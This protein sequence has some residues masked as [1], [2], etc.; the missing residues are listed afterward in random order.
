M[1]EPIERV[2]N[3][4]YTCPDCG[5]VYR[6]R[7]SYD[8]HLG[9][10]NPENHALAESIVGRWLRWEDGV[11]DERSVHVG[12]AVGVVDYHLVSVY[13]LTVSTDYRGYMTRTRDYEWTVIRP[14]LVTL[15]GSE[16]EARAYWR[17]LM[18]DVMFQNWERIVARAAWDIGI[19]NEP[20]G[21]GGDE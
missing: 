14:D 10:C 13:V 21:E 7:E 18:E 19:S 6:S 4:E 8:R 1:S 16:E 9:Y 12:R 15:F 3:V 2:V 5:H 17:G 11:C 20:E